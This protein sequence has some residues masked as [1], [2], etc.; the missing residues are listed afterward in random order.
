M[1]Y[2][3]ALVGLV[4]GAV[5]GYVLRREVVETSSGDSDRRLKE[6]RQLHASCGDRIR[7]LSLQVAQLESQVAEQAVPD[8]ERP[9]YQVDDPAPH[10]IPNPPVELSDLP[11]AT[12][13][14]LGRD[15]P[16][17]APESD[18]DDRPAE[19][20]VLNGSNTAGSNAGV[21]ESAPVTVEAAPHEVAPL[22]A[23]S[24]EVASGKGTSGSRG[25]TD[26]DRPWPGAAEQR[27]APPRATAVEDV[28]YVEIDL[29]LLEDDEEADAVSQDPDPSVA[30][31]TPEQ[32]TEEQ[33]PEQG[34]E[35]QGTPLTVISG[36]GAISATR[37]EAAGISSVEELAALQPADVRKLVGGLGRLGLR[38]QR[39]DWVNAAREHVANH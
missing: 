14:D 26:S 34:S 39:E 31:E 36:I 8:L 2:V 11:S 19:L 20:D 22:A 18:T 6:L 30:P 12:V 33:Q 9:T 17:D 27:S 24:T 15:Q 35:E 5:C 7:T 4:L 28:P 1:I 37:L 38:L 10:P 25:G 16:D 32:E 29:E 23:S 13:T 3:A 21:G